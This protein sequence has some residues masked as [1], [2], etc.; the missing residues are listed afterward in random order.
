M[1]T[2]DPV[3]KSVQ[4]YLRTQSRNIDPATRER[5]DAMR[6]EA[7][8]LAERQQQHRFNPWLRNA[9]FAGAFGVVLMAGLITLNTQPDIELQ[10]T[11]ALELVLLNEDFELLGEDL[12]FYD[13]IEGELDSQGS[14]PTI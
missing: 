10:P 7:V 2:E 9:G 6:R 4:D 5:L 13:W 12:A 8:A 3:E 11:S 1:A 14:T